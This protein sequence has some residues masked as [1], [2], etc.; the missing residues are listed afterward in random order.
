MSWF[1]L[2]LVQAQTMQLSPN[3][4]LFFGRIPVGKTAVRKF[5][6]RNLDNTDLDISSIRLEGAGAS[7]F[8]ILND[9]G[10]TTVTREVK[11]ILDVQ[12]QP[13]DI[14]FFSVWLII[15]SNASS[16]PDWIIL[17]GYGTNRKWGVVVFE[18]IFG[19]I[20]GDG[21]GSVRITPDGGFILG[22]ST[23]QQEREY[24]DATLIKLDQFGQHEWQRIYGIEEWSENFRETIPTSDGGYIMAGSK[25]HSKKQIPS[26]VWVV[27]FDNDGDIEWE[28]EYG[29]N[30][31]DA[32]GYVIETSDGGFLVSGSYQHDTQDRQDSDALL[33]KLPAGGPPAEWVKTYGGENGGEGAGVVAE[34]AE[35][36]Y[37]FSGSTSSSG[38][39]EWDGW[40]VQV[41]ANGD[42][43]W[44]MT[45]GD[46]DWDQLGALEPT[47]DGGYILGGWTASYGAVARD[48]YLVKVEADGT[49]EWRQVWGDAHKDGVSCIIQTSDGGYMV[50][51]STENTFWNEFW[52]TDGIVMKLDD[53]G[54]V[55]WQE[56][57]G[58][59]A[60][61]GLGTIRETADGGFIIN[62]GTNS[63]YNNGEI[64][65]IKID[66]DGGLTAVDAE[67]QTLPDAYALV[68][69]YPNPFN[70]QTSIRYTLPERTHI[71]LE[72]YNVQGR[73]VA[74][75]VEGTVEAGVHAVSWNA[76]DQ[77]TGLYLARLKAGE[78]V[79]T[80]RMLLLK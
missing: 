12:F 14:G 11:L 16:S 26:D 17:S 41:E 51:G 68:Q 67:T 32:A 73:L 60:D 66:S 15:E 25:S 29:G 48:F 52:R 69:N 42:E 49:F 43:D 74:T 13:A 53:E 40:L 70:A 31:G 3:D 27:K 8:S 24:G 37:I 76:A 38:A 20:L 4:T 78:V 19:D 59:Y 54:E 6:I 33:I 79:Q 44:A 46:T 56:V 80:R 22:G 10:A 63:Y 18:R 55:Q 72:I 39:G 75:L 36:K 71:K 28:Y 57:F 64:Y 61:D 2:S 5:T 50:T 34:T 47:A 7:S 35:G 9:P 65:L 21:S 58:R 45:Y 62:G 23:T 1:G 77:A 30:E